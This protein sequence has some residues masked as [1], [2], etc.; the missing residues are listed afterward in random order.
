MVLVVQRLGGLGVGRSHSCSRWLLEST[1]A[2][3][4]QSAL[5]ATLWICASVVSGLAADLRFLVS[6]R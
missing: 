3:R 4:L 5:R 1:A 6:H 2:T